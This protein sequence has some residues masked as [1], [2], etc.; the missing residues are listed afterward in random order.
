MNLKDELKNVKETLESKE[1]EA[2]K[3]SEEISNV[4]E[5]L[6]KSEAKV[7]E[8]E[9]E[10]GLL[11]S[12]IETLNAKET[13]ELKEDEMVINK[14]EYVAQLV[15]SVEESVKETITGRI[16]GS[17]KEEI[18][19]SFKAELDY[20]ANIKE[21]LGSQPKQEVRLPGASSKKTVLSQIGNADFLKKHKLI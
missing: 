18:D 7:K 1:I 13:L 4:K 16:V 19:N 3:L 5:L 17:T 11:K 14:A 12:E 20:I 21:S 6:T 10:N 8:L 15:N 2:Q 9:T